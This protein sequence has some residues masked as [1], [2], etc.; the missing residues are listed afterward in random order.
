M[1][2]DEKK[3]VSAILVLEVLGRPPEYL[4]ETLNNLIKTIGE[5]K[6][7]VVKEAKINT[8]VELKEQKGF[9]ASFTEIEVEVEEILY[10]AILMFKYMPAHV[11]IVSPANINLPTAGWN[12]IFN[13]LVRRLHG[14]EEIAK[15]MQTEKVIL[16]NQLRTLLETE[17]KKEEKK[18]IKAKKTRKKK[19]EK[20][21]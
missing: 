5:E 7:T 3:K 2:S 12:D 15:M 20:N 6:G 4:T 14:Y 17:N 16:E 8:P 13:E 21:E 11:E 10:L 18:D 19:E 1:S 9:Y